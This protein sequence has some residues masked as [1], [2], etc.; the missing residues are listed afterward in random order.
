MLL[1]VRSVTLEP[2]S[3]SMGA[4]ALTGAFLSTA[5]MARDLLL[6]ELFFVPSPAMAH[7]GPAALRLV[8]L[9]THLEV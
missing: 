4:D 6:Q 9:H 2:M 5:Q 3:V 7:R 1:F 8:W